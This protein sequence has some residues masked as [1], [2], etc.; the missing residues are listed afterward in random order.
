[1]ILKIKGQQVS[2]ELLMDA[3][4]SAYEAY[5]CDVIRA[6]LQS[7]RIYKSVPYKVFAPKANLVC[8]RCYSRDGI[9]RTTKFVYQLAFEEGPVGRE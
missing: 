7:V 1:M 2:S 8:Q 4:N 9:V 5:H 6:H 3:V